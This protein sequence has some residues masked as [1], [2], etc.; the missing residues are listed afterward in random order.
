MIS[1]SDARNTRVVVAHRNGPASPCPDG[2]AAAVLIHD[3]L[4]QA[5]VRF[6]AHG[7]ELDA[8]RPE[9]GMLFVDVAPPRDRAVEFAEAGAIVLDHHASQKDVVEMFGA[10]GI[11][12]DHP[13]VSGAVLAFD[14]V[15]LPAAEANGVGLDVVERARDFALLAGVR[16]TWQRDDPRW[17]ESCAQAAALRFWPWERLAAVRDP[18]GA[19]WEELDLLVRTTGGQLHA[20]A[21]ER[22][23]AEAGWVIRVRT[24]GGTR[25][26]LSNTL[27]TSDLAELVDADVLVGWRLAGDDGRV[28]IQASMRARGPYDVA[29]VAR[30]MGGGGHR[31]AAGL[32]VTLGPDLV[33]FDPIAFVV[34]VFDR[35][36]AAPTRVEAPPAP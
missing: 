21:L 31:A 24:S 5:E 9:H 10:R 35:H 14:H 17:E 11:Y 16:D 8:V 25:L 13:G 27:E 1:T 3:A 22:A 6:A 34:G 20:N 28:R 12:D 7:P 32:G 36:E 2:T 19:G 4:P 23:R 30:S 33:S 26:A 15:W 29:A 18:F